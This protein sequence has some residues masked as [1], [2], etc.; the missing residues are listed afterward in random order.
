MPWSSP[1]YEVRI[2]IPSWSFSTLFARDDISKRASPNRELNIFR[3]YRA[4]SG[5]P[6][7]MMLISSLDHGSL[8][9]T[10]FLQILINRY[11][12]HHIQ[13]ISYIP[14]KSLTPIKNTSWTWYIILIISPF[15]IQSSHKR[16]NVIPSTS[17]Y[18]LYATTNQSILVIM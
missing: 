5:D 10:L 4:H 15:S 14:L 13:N 8:F 12:S 6:Q 16:V 1:K 2:F 3:K 7:N 18:C 11:I 9:V 17:F